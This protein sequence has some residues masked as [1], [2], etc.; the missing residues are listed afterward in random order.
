MTVIMPTIESYEVFDYTPKLH[1][2]SF[3]IMSKD[4][5]NESLA[6]RKFALVKSFDTLEE[7]RRFIVGTEYVLQYKFKELPE[8]VDNS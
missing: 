7:A 2:A 1:G 6:N 3:S 4:S 8:D 5:I